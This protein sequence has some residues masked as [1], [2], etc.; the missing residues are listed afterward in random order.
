MIHLVY[1]RFSRYL[2]MQMIHL[3]YCIKQQQHSRMSI[4][5]SS[6][7]EAVVSCNEAMYSV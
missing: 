6:C 7:D 5:L 4:L 1:V 3:M 2:I